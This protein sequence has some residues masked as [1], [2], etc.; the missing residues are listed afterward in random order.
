MDCDFSGSSLLWH[1][2]CN[3]FRV[4][5]EFCRGLEI[6]MIEVIIM[7][8]YCAAFSN[9]SSRRALETHP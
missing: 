1:L 8:V 4:L 5:A 9:E 7:E 2:S 3:F 6:L